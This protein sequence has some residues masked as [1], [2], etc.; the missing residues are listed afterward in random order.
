MVDDLIVY[1]FREDCSARRTPA[2]EKDLAWSI[3]FACADLP[4]STS[5]AATRLVSIRAEARSRLLIRSPLRRAARAAVPFS[6]A[7][8]GTG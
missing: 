1:F 2:R 6:A 5:R 3:D 7:H 4:V 8:V